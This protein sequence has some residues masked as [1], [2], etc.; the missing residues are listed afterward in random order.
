MLAEHLGARGFE[1]LLSS[2]SIGRARGASGRGFRRP[3]HHRQIRAPGGALAVLLLLGIAVGPW[4][5]S[6]RA[7]AHRARRTPPEA[8]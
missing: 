8:S 3:R 6:A 7:A 1:V 4:G 2:P 5:L